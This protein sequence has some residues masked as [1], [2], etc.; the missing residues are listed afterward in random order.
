MSTQ[1][2]EGIRNPE[3]SIPRSNSNPGN[4]FD[5]DWFRQKLGGLAAKGILIGTSSWKYPGWIGSLYSQDKYV[6]RGKVSE[7]RFERTCL[8]EYA[9]V[10]HTVCVDAAY[11]TFPTEKYLAGLAAQVPDTFQFTFKVTD[12]IT[13][14]HFPNLPRFGARAGT[15]NESF[16]NAPL[17]VN[18][19]LAPLE[20]IR[21]KV[22][23]LMFEFSR[24]Y[25]SDF[26]RGRDFIA[27]LDGFLAQLPKGWRYGVEIRNKNFLHPEYFACLEKHGVAHVFNSW[28]AMPSLAEQ[29]A[30]PGNLTAP[31]VPARLLLKPGRDYEEAVKAFS[32]YDRIRDEYPEGRTAAVELMRKALKR[33]RKPALVYVN[34]RFEGYALAT[35][36]KLTEELEAKQAS[37]PT[38]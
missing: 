19:F 17:F 9:E 11:Y 24:F 23:V 34:N 20:S 6:F 22:G 16:L 8:E 25:P 3:P 35:I 28:E 2:L 15:D 7:A 30:L 4:G 21:P 31:F 29:V 18:R 1:E 14:R 12:E 32:P 10:F 37:A 5:R 26:A 27:A 38:P 36:R 33:G 13:I